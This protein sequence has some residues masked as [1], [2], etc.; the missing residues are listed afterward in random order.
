MA[1]PTQFPTESPTSLPTRT[2]T[3]IPTSLPTPSP[4][5]RF[6]EKNILEEQEV[7]EDHIDPYYL[8]LRGQAFVI[9]LGK[10]TKIN[11]YSFITVGILICTDS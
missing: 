6:L 2:P 5:R 7:M 9:L 10:I 11:V 3:M 1:S 8:S 4:T